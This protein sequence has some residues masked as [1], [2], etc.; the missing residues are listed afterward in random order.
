MAKVKG[1]HSF[2]NIPAQLLPIVSLRDY[3][4]RQPFRDEPAIRIWLTSKISSLIGPA[5]SILERYKAAM[6][7][8]VLC[9]PA[10][11]G[12]AAADPTKQG[13]RQPAF[14]DA[15][16]TTHHPPLPAVNPAK[17]RGSVC[18]RVRPRALQSRRNR[19]M[20]SSCR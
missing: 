20:R 9:E 8:T 12:Q 6:H 16:A 15:L 4:L 17:K 11:K 14:I 3:T 13:L 7:H 5:Y 2:F 1:R 18:P 19:L 10:L